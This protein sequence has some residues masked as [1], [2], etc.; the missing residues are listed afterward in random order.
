MA[1]Y[2]PA[3]DGTTHTVRLG[4]EIVLSLPENPT[5]GYRWQLVSAGT[6]T[7]RTNGDHYEPGGTGTGAG[8]TRTLRFIA[9]EP[10]D[11]TLRLV[12]RRSW[13]ADGEEA[14]SFALTLHVAS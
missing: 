12:N 1:E 14:G 7:L 11:A 3:D 6:P 9:A 2:G 8:G 4:E 5:T 10:G 13:E